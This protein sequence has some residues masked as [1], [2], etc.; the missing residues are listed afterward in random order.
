[1]PLRNLDPE[2]R[3]SMARSAFDAL[4]RLAS[5]AAPMDMIPFGE[6]AAQLRM[7]K[8]LAP[9]DIAACDRRECPSRTTGC[10]P[11]RRKLKAVA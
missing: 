2:L 10:M 7:I 8:L 1:M 9:V 11:R 6:L 5:T 4:D 3:L